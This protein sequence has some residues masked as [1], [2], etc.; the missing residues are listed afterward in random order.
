VAFLAGLI[1]AS[2][3]RVVGDC[4]HD[5]PVDVTVHEGGCTTIFP[6][7]AYDSIQID[8]PDIDSGASCFLRLYQ[9]GDDFC[10]GPVLATWGP[11]QDNNDLGVECAP[12]TDPT[13][14]TENAGPVSLTC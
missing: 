2:T 14:G 5:H 1:Q 6:N 4:T 10:G 8:N 7:N 13:T 9:F 11:F 12:I 3:V